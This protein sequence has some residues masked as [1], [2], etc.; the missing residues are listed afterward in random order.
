MRNSLLFTNSQSKKQQMLNV[1]LCIVPGP[2]FKKITCP[3]GTSVR[4]LLS[5]NKDFT[6]RERIDY[7]KRIISLMHDS[8]PG[9][10]KRIS[11]DY[12]LSPE[13]L[14]IDEGDKEPIINLYIMQ[15]LRP[16]PHPPT[17]E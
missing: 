7:E 5:L 12:S 11:L 4:E 14:R 13:D 16:I 6:M 3:E 1:D 15:K 17:R 10:E 8:Y 9:C 2:G